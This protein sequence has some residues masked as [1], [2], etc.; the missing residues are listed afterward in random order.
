MTQR[1]VIVLLTAL[2]LGCS[3]GDENA[4]TP[5]GE[6]IQYSVQVTNATRR[7]LPRAQLWLATPSARAA[8]QR[9]SAVAVEQPHRIVG[10]A[11]GNRQIYL[12]FADVPVGFDEKIDVEAW[13]EFH[14]SPDAASVDLDPQYLE[15]MPG[16]ESTDALVRERAASLA[17]DEAAATASAILAWTAELEL[18]PVA[19]PEDDPSHMEALAPGA[20]EDEAPRGRGARH[21]LE[22]GS[23]DESDRAMLTVALLRAAGIPARA[24]LGFSAEAGV[25]LTSSHIGLWIEYAIEGDWRHGLLD[26]PTSASDVRVI[27]LRVID[28][29][30]A[31]PRGREFT[32]LYEAV[33]LRAELVN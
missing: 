18:A 26:A 19:M 2:A 14:D 5:A 33:G 12:E 8:S 30:S 31:I 32:F 1:G 11:H 16:V 6:R 21:A 13:I 17:R 23:G 10:T 15:P 7:V 27:A 22:T 3:S 25:P 29:P 28:D 24:V 4:A 20:P 9:V